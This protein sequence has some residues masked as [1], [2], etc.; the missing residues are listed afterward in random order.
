MRHENYAM[1][2][3]ILPYAGTPQKNIYKHRCVLVHYEKKHAFKLNNFGTSKISKLQLLLQL[4]FCL[5]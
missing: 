1:C 5:V 4:L 2:H 3:F